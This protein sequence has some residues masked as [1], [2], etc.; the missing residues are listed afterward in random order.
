MSSGFVSEKVLDEKR[1]QRQEEWEKVRKSSDPRE[2]PEEPQDSR[3][4]FERLQE[5]KA[6]AQ[7]EWDEAHKL[8]NQIRGIDDDE[9]EFLDEV[10]AVKSSME[11]ER[12]AE[13]RKAL[14]DY[15]K[16]QAELREKQ[17]EERLKLETKPPPVPI[18]S[19]LNK[20]QSQSKLLSGVVVR[21]RTAPVNNETTEDD[22]QNKSQVG[23]EKAKKQKLGALAE[24]GEYASSSDDNEE[25]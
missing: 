22:A 5:N 12:L 18:S 1:R 19:K 20:S 21:K 4:L 16:E 14:E 6:K 23:E 9:A 3:S 2:A 11:R 10:D 7:E 15:H 8:K 25:A 17:L 13:E 24:L